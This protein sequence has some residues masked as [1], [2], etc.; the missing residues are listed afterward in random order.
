M[1]S[2]LVRLRAFFERDGA[3]AWSLL[4][5]AQGTERRGILETLASTPVG[6]AAPDE[7]SREWYEGAYCAVLDAAGL[8]PMPLQSSLARIREMA[9]RPTV[10]GEPLLVFCDEHGKAH[11]TDCSETD[12][13]WHAR[14]AAGVEEE[15]HIPQAHARYDRATL[16]KLE[17]MFEAVGPDLIEAIE[18]LGPGRAALV[19]EL[20]VGPAPENM[21]NGQYVVDVRED[22]ATWRPVRHPGHPAEYEGDPQADGLMPYDENR[23]E[24]PPCPPHPEA[25]AAVRPEFSSSGST[26]HQW[27]GNGGTWAAWWAFGHIHARCLGAI[28]DPGIALPSD[29]ID[30]CLE[31][32]PRTDTPLPEGA[33]D[34]GGHAITLADGSSVWLW[35]A[36]T[37]PWCLSIEDKHLSSDQTQAAAYLLSRTEGS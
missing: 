22:G 30:R 15:R 4:G 32:R 5:D 27:E 28:G 9:A 26:E 18:A 8:E 25:G 11:C 10:G 2:D 12:D 1:A 34:N 20:T 6:G 17:E 3:G 21:A 37:G 19:L 31:D 33:T 16:A 36:G 7:P 23:R 14:K 13:G 35:R 24:P 29:I